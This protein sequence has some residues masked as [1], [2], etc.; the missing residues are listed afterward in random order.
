MARL[1]VSPRLLYCWKQNPGNN[2]I[3]AVT[4][5]NMRAYG[6]TTAYTLERVNYGS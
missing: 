4:L 6:A 2:S 1:P 3:A 5:E